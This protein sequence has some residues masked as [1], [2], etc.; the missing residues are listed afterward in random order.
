[1][2]QKLFSGFSLYIRERLLHLYEW[3]VVSGRRREEYYLEYEEDRE[4][5]NLDVVSE[6]SEDPYLLTDEEISRI[7]NKLLEKRE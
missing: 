6:M 1:M 3:I 5:E 7:C 2:F 4:D